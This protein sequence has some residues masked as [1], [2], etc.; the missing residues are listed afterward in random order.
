MTAHATEEQLNA[1]RAALR[2]LV[3]DEANKR[4]ARGAQRR[5]AKRAGLSEHTASRFLHGGTV[6]RAAAQLVLD[7]A[8]GAAAAP[9]EATLGDA[10]VSAMRA[11]AALDDAARA[12]VIAWT[13]ARW[14]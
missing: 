7:R 11:L 8:T 1:A 5:A 13:K 4:G 2:D 3:R 14:E 9:Q 6:S 12:R 10:E